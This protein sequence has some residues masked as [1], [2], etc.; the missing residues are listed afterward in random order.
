MKIEHTSNPSTQDIDFLTQQINRDT[1]DFGDSYPFAFFIRD[2]KGTII[3]GC[4]GSVVFG[5]IYTDQLW[6]R[7][8]YRKQGLGRALMD[9]VHEYGREVG[10]AMAT[11][12]TMDF[13]DAREFYERLGYK[14][15][16]QRSGY[17]GKSHC[18]FLSRGL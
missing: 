13:Q 14:S 9:S 3:A 7:S 18:I 6:V 2:D 5:V 15:D 12:A 1:P 8:D 4:N 10:C 16:F 11:A 17:V